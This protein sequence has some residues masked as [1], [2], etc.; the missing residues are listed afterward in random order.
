M[1]I[2]KLWGLK[3]L[4]LICMFLLGRD[5]ATEKVKKKS[6]FKRVEWKK[7]EFY[8]Y[9]FTMMSLKPSS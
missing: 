9:I 8:S 2:L 1:I 4:K 7:K 3:F 6:F 5:S